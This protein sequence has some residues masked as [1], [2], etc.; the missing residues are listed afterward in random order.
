MTLIEEIG[1]Y[2]IVASPKARHLAYCSATAAL[3]AIG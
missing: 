3:E 2:I 1:L